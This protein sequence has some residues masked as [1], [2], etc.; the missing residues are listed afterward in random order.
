MR[1]RS[2]VVPVARRAES[3]EKAPRGSPNPCVGIGRVCEQP[4]TLRAHPAGPWGHPHAGTGCPH[5]ALCALPC[6][7]QLPPGAIPTLGTDHH[8]Q[9]A[10]EAREPHAKLNKATD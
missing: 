7:A 8:R 4:G 10:G 5:T 1:I 2:L 3:E 9:Q 6:T